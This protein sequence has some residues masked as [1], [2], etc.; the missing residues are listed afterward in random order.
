VARE[1]LCGDMQKVINAENDS[2]REK[3]A[4]EE[5]EDGGE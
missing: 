2:S 3:R 4:E 5:T 1:T